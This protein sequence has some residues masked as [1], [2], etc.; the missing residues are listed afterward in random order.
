[1][2]NRRLGVEY[3][4]NGFQTPGTRDLP[5]PQS[6][7]PDALESINAVDEFRPDFRTDVTSVSVEP[8]IEKVV[9]DCWQAW[10]TGVGDGEEGVDR[11]KV[12]LNGVAMTMLM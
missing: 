7:A 1:M 3:Q 12:R 2:A 8:Y 9:E 5:D 6:H 10:E 11:K 4:V